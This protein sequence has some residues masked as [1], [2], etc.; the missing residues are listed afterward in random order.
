MICNALFPTDSVVDP[1]PQ[2]LTQIESEFHFCSNLT[3]TPK[4]RVDTSDTFESAEN[5]YFWN[6]DIYTKTDKMI[7]GDENDTDED[8]EALYRGLGCSY[9][10][11]TSYLVFLPSFFSGLQLVI[12]TTS[13]IC[14]H[15]FTF[16]CFRFSGYCIE[17]FNI[18]IRLRTIGKGTRVLI[19]PCGSFGLKPMLTVLVLSTRQVFF[20]NMSRKLQYDSTEAF[21]TYLCLALITTDFTYTCCIPGNL[22][23]TYTLPNVFKLIQFISL[24]IEDKRHDFRLMTYIGAI[25][26]RLIPTLKDA[27]ADRDMVAKTYVFCYIFVKSIVNSKPVYV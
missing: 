3:D 7:T 14:L 10:A 9:S 2:E 16:H 23:N 12:L 27:P 4:I 25:V 19:V 8:E 21:G 11:N 22:M 17:S 13:F 18:N 20:V 5:G 15:L 6:G 1:T 26:K 24:D